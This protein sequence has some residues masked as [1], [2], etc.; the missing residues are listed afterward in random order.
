M[1]QLTDA[2]LNVVARHLI[3]INVASVPTPVSTANPLPVTSVDGGSAHATP[4]ALTS[5]PTNLT[6]GANTA[7]TFAST[8]YVITVENNSGEDK[9]VAIPSPA[10]AGSS[11]VLDGEIREF[12]VAAGAITVGI[13]GASAS[14]LNGS[15]ASNVIV[16]GRA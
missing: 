10:T 6:A 15:A 12:T 4:V 5:P 11:K 2:L 1:S 9:N 14:N 3:H 7:L 13:Y 16:E 8:V